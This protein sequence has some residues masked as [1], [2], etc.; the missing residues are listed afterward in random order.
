MS[1]DFDQ[2]IDRYNTAS[3]KW[4]GVERMFGAKDLIPMWVADMDFM[5][6]HTIMDAMK[7]RVDHGMFGYTL[8]TDAYCE[9][10]IGWMKRRYSWDIKKEWIYHSPGVVSALSFIV[11]SFTK[12]GD[13]VVI[14]PPVYYPFK[15]VVDANGCEL[16][17][18][19]LKW[20]DGTYKMDLED[21]RRK[22][23][24]VKVIILSNPHNPVGRV[25]R[26]DELEALGRLCIDHN[27]LVVSDEIHAD[28]LFP[29][30]KHIPFAS[31][32]E[33]FA[34]HSIVCTAASK[35]FNI[36]GLKNSNIIIP[37]PEIAKQYEATIKKFHVVG[38]NIFG[39]LATEIA[40]TQGELW[41]EELLAY[42]HQN[43]I[44]LTEY[45]EK[46]IKELTV[47]Q[48]EGTYLIWIDCKKLGMEPK[49]LEQF[50]RRE[51]K[52]AIDD[53]YIFGPGGE[54]F[55]RINIACPRFILAEGLKQIEQAVAKHLGR[56]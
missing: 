25:W 31:I 52:V 38:A 22:I 39:A 48:P 33:E 36:A 9:A 14:Q 16:V 41:L 6:P 37:N 7:K 50:M 24:G 3:V 56:K 55:I 27:V 30:Y 47:I 54:G 18:N 21:L 51:A 11:H 49:Q 40:Y 45:I 19:P 10:V 20:E 32:S 42:L 13:K 44:F 4:D 15:E 29:G 12:P 1:F 5:L 43:L 8:K 26:K 23:Q 28:L 35:T 34:Q 17:Y 46:N 2:R 53:G